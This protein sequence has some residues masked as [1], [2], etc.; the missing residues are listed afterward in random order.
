MSSPDVA[1]NPAP[2]GQS[3]FQA[4]ESKNI[5]SGSTDFLESNSWIAKLAFLLLVI[6]GFVLLFRLA[7]TLLSSIFAPSGKSIL[8]NGL[9]NGNTQTIVSQDPGIKS[10]KTIIRSIN[11]KPGIEFTWSTWLFLN[12]FDNSNKY[13]HVFNKGNISFDT[14][15][16]VTPNN[17]P[18][19]YLS[20]GYQGLRVVLNTFER[21]D[22]EIIDINDLPMN[23]WFNVMVRVQDKFCDVYINGRLTKRRIMNA[24]VK[25]NYDN[26]NVAM[27][28]GFNGYISNLT[29][30]N[31]AIGIAEIQN[32]ITAGPNLKPMDNNLATAKPRYLAE[33]WFFDQNAV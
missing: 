31:S 13:H 15:G 2:A 19:I 33:R 5:V 32:I 28:G 16:I 11:E 9:L 4:F 23:K 10:S 22:A 24:V 12:G 30:F 21:P 1:P 17:A 20:P 29:Y 3:A 27:N 14:Q 26:V 7:V 6:I 25:Q 8:I 18:G